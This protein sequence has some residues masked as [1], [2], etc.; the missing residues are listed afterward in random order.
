M[1]LKDIYSL[2]VKKG[3][4]KDLR[5]TEVIAGLLQA[6]QRKFAELS[7][8]EEREYDREKLASPYHD[9]RILYGDPDLEVRTVLAG[10]DVET[11]EMILADRLRAAGAGVDLVLAHHPEG[12]ALANLHLVMQAQLDLMAKHGVPINVAEGIMAGRIAEVERNLRPLNLNRAVDAAAL[13]DLPFMCVHSAADN[14]AATYIQNLVDENKPETLKDIVRLLKEIPE[15]AAAAAAGLDALSITAGRGSSRAGKVLV[16]MAGG[17]SGSELMYEKLAL[18]GIGT[19]LVMHIPEKNLKEAKKHH[20]HVIVANHTA[21]DSLGMNL[22]L[23]ELEHEGIEIRP[24]SGLI[25]HSR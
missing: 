24:C 22:F 21:S 16:M 13:L 23:D 4:E 18:A 6:E 15:Y 9:T 10:I 11:G 1:K 20:V 19:V 8:E 3:L 5:G 12:K 7:P 14:L 25:R 17:T 2:A